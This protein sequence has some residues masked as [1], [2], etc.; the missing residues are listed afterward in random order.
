MCFTLCCNAHPD[1]SIHVRPCPAVLRCRPSFVKV[2]CD[3]SIRVAFVYRSFALDCLP[4]FGNVRSDR[5]IHVS[6]VLCSFDFVCFFFTLLAVAGRFTCHPF[7]T[8]ISCRKRSTLACDIPLR[9]FRGLCS[10]LLDC[11]K[12]QNW[13]GPKRLIGPRRVGSWKRDFTRLRLR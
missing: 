13:C 2:R 11:G 4:V 1:W 10:I 6:L 9:L 8:A 12:C 7:L 5:P 3:W